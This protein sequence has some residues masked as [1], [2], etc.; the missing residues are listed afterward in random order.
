[1]AGYSI[2]WLTKRNDPTPNALSTNED[3]TFLRAYWLVLSHFDVAGPFQFLLKLSCS[4]RIKEASMH[5][6]AGIY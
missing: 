4:P 1:M 5:A 3:C 6:T 2:H